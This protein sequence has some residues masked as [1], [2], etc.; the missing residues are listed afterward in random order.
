VK[1]YIGRYY[2]K[3]IQQLLEQKERIKQQVDDT[4]SQKEMILKELMYT[5]TETTNIRGLYS[6]VKNGYD[7][8]LLSVRKHIKHEAEQLNDKHKKV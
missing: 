1:K 4:A 2:E 7:E 5:Q 8:E 6:A 3:L